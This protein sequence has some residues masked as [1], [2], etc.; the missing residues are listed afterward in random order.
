MNQDIELEILKI[1]QIIKKN[2]EAEEEKRNKNSKDIV[3]VLKSMKNSIETTKEPLKVKENKETQEDLG[4]KNSINYFI[5]KIRENNHK[6]SEVYDKVRQIKSIQED[7][8]DIEKIIDNINSSLRISVLN[9]I[10]IGIIA[11]LLGSNFFFVKLYKESQVK[12]QE[13]YDEYLNEYNSL[14][15]VLT[16]DSKYWYDKD[17]QE[18]YIKATKTPEKP[19]ETEK[20]DKKKK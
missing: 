2:Q 3:E 8:F 13:I 15:K 16:G 11:L 19:K 10:L 6:I 9:Y 20:K 5:E 14:Q 1:L 4:I 17:Q 12:N 7:K 18:L